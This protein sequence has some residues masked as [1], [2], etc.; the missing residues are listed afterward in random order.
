[1]YHRRMAPF[2]IFILAGG[3]STRMGSDKAFLELDGLPL[4]DR[5]LAL[6]RT[7]SEMVSIVGERAKFSEF[8]PV[9]EDV[10]P[11][12][13]PLGGIHAALASSQADCNLILGIDLP[14]LTAPLLRYVRSEAQ[15]SGA[16]V[17]VPFASGHYHTLCAVYRKEFASVAESALQS[18]KNR[19]D[20]LFAGVP[21]RLLEEAELTQA[22]FHASIFRNVNTPEDWEQAK[23]EFASRQHVSWPKQP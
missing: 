1:M 7:V 18:G 9:I 2:S 17:T 13:G 10:Y 14:F 15:A 8:A 11:S 20:T 16:T 19:I 23:Q 21:V 6:A 12:H 3:K 22:G 4:I 5:V